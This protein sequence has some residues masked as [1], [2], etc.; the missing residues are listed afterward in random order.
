MRTQGH[1]Q[2]E[3]CTFSSMVSTPVSLPS[4]LRV[5]LPTNLFQPP[6][7]LLYLFIS[8]SDL[9]FLS[10]FHFHTHAHSETVRALSQ[11]PLQFTGSSLGSTLTE[12]ML[13]RN[14]NLTMTAT[15]INVNIIPQNFRYQ[16][17]FTWKGNSRLLDKGLYCS[18]LRGP[19][20]L[21]DLII[22][23]HF[24]LTHLSQ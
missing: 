20:C 8:F 14:A 19:L 16:F 24:V 17:A 9:I 23:C 7:P 21:V 3:V 1:L 22:C 12:M 5:C 18:C 6:P 10:D 4:L 15:A 2:I 13:D 11:P